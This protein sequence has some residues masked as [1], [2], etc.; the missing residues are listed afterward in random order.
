FKN[1]QMYVL[2]NI[3]QD[4]YTK[5]HNGTITTMAA[6]EAEVHQTLETDKANEMP[7]PFLMTGVSDEFSWTGDTDK[8]VEVSLKRAIAKVTLVLHYDWDK[9]KYDSNLST[10]EDRFSMMD[11]GAET[12]VGVSATSASTVNSAEL[13]FEGY[14]AAKKTA[15]YTFYVNE[16]DLTKAEAAQ[17]LPPYLL[18]KL[19]SIDDPNYSLK[20][21]VAPAANAAVLDTYYRLVFPMTMERNNFYTLHAHISEAG[22]DGKEGARTLHFNLKVEP[23]HVDNM[24]FAPGYLRAD[25][26]EWLEG[27]NL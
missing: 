24:N 15:T 18:L 12:K 11:F 2:A 7:K 10:T 17:A 13:K 14:D 19:K 8:E 22:S 20:S 1:V 26:A 3:K 16:Y 23:W 5:L 25:F 27:D 21:G 4:L 6:L 9:L